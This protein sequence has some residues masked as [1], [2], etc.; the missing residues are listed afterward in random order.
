MTV[1]KHPEYLAK[2]RHP[3]W[4]SIESEWDIF[5][6]M[7][8]IRSINISKS[9][10]ITDQR[11]IAPVLPNLR[12]ARLSGGFYPGSLECIL[13]TS[14]DLAELHLVGVGEVQHVGKYRRTGTPTLIPFLDLCS[15]T[16]GRMPNLKILTLSREQTQSTLEPVRPALESWACFLRQ[17]ADQLEVLTLEL[18]RPS[19]FRWN[20]TDAQDAFMTHIV[21]LLKSGEF[22]RVKR[23]ELLG[24]ARLT[25]EDAT[26]ITAVLPSE[27]DFLW[28]PALSA[29]DVYE[30]ALD[31]FINFMS[32]S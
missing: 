28:T 2:A 27:V 3:A 19:I 15:S 17:Y 23:I 30:Y 5:P 4:E 22:K 32:D 11:T 20:D 31:E 29:L 7:T 26:Q 21:P 12:S 1:R 24:A 8:N 16:P 13:L 25:P 18:E 14:P 10:I 9:G 6:G